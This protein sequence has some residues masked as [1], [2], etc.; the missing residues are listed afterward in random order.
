MDLFIFF[1]LGSTLNMVLAFP[2]PFCLL[3]IFIDGIFK[4]GASTN[5]DDEFP[6]NAY[7]YLTRLR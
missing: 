2:L 4:A 1:A 5:P 7:E 3:P 6:I